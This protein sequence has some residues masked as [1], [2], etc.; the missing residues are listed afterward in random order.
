MMTINI[1][2]NSKPI[3]PVI[4]I[5]N[6]ESV[7]PLADTLS[8]SGFKTLE[9]TL[10]TEFGIPAIELLREQRPDL[11]V[12][13]GTVK[14]ITQLKSAIAAG[15]E[16]IVS[17]GFDSALVDTANTLG[18]LLIPGVMSPSEIM[19]AENHGLTLIK[20]FP[21]SMAGGVPFIKSMASVFPA[22]TFFPTGGITED[23]VSEYL[24]LS[25]VVCAGGTWLTPLSLLESQA[26]NKIHEIAQR[27]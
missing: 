10:R 24:Q 2:E 8:Q 16:F 27:C 4:T 23:N 18:C 14:N 7:L 3:V 21:A 17:P 9:I 26:W 13:A 5:P 11:T 25:N 12:G 1:V 15:S 22:M 20:L 6:M 19:S